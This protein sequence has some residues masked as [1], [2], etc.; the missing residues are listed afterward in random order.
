MSTRNNDNYKRIRRALDLTNNDVFEI[1]QEK[2]SKSQIDGWSRSV[3]AVKSGTG[4]SR[5][6]T[7]SRFRPMSD[8]QFD[9]FCSG[10]IDWMK[11][12][13]ES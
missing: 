11:S 13:D 10:L 3:D 12:G 5:A 2:Y 7:I 4:N 8:G 1:L 9:D 6:N